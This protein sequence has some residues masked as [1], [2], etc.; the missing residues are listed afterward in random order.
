MGDLRQRLSRSDVTIRIQT[1]KMNF[2]R[3]QLA[4]N[5]VSPRSPDPVLRLPSRSSSPPRH[6]MTSPPL[7]CR[8]ESLPEAD[9]DDA[10]NAVVE[11]END[12]NAEERVHFVTEVKVDVTSLIPTSCDSVTS[13]NASA[14]VLVTHD[15]LNTPA[16]CS[17]A[18]QKAQATHDVTTD[19]KHSRTSAA[20]QTESRSETVD[21]S[22]D[23]SHSQYRDV[24]ASHHE[25][26]HSHHG[27]VTHSGFCSEMSPDEELELNMASFY[28]FK[29]IPRSCSEYTI[30]Y[31]VIRRTKIDFYIFYRQQMSARSSCYVTRWKFAARSCSSLNNS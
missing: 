15:T 21:R 7:R 6:P 27:D 22:Q 24:T 2:Y 13:L 31:G 5:G 18:N 26:S 30:K 29:V 20:A 25:E 11:K 1:D 4:E 19:N 28:K 12:V 9:S 3:E 16:Y 17:D 14:P 8:L 23:E 10:D